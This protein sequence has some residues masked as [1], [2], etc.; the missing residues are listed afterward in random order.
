[1]KSSHLYKPFFYS[2]LI[3]ILLSASAGFFTSA[4]DRKSV[5]ASVGDKITLQCGNA[6]LGNL[7]QLTW[8]K[9]DNNKSETI[10]SYLYIQNRTFM[11][12]KTV[13]LWWTYEEPYRLQIMKLQ[14]SDAGNY[15]CNLNGVNVELHF[16]WHVIITESV[17]DRTYWTLYTIPIPIGIILISVIGCICCRRCFYN[18]NREELTAQNGSSNRNSLVPNEVGS[19]SEFYERINSVYNL[20]R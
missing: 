1:M 2:E 12:N 8:S 14:I 16:K 6:S 5:T 19:G 18:T 15:S 3:L 13:K 7:T 17:S 11:S 4:D 9:E 10:Y 20:P